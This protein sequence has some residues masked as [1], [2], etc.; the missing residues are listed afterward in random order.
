MAAFD[1]FRRRHENIWTKL[2][3]I[4]CRIGATLLWKDVDGFLSADPK[5]IPE[6]QRC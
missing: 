4:T 2:P 6:S 5:I 3:Q 1:S